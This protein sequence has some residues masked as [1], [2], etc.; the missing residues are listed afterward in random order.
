MLLFFI[1][2]RALMTQEIGDYSRKITDGYENLDQISIQADMWRSKYL[3][4]R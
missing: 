1:R 3:A 4:C 2:D